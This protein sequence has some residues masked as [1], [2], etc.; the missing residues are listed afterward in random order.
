[1]T[2]RWKCENK[3]LLTLPVVGFSSISLVLFSL[4]YEYPKD[5]VTKVLH[6]CSLALQVG[7]QWSSCSIFCCGHTAWSQIIN[8]LTFPPSL[9]TSSTALATFSA[10]SNT[11]FFLLFLEGLLG[12]F[13]KIAG[14]EFGNGVLSHSLGH[15]MG[16]NTGSYATIYLFLSK[17]HQHNPLVQLS[18]I[19]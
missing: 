1:M 5:L 4:S 8:L 7:Q 13:L 12:I 16:N 18:C 3:L 2:R 10:S 17:N 6:L 11:A 9:M 15:G 14:I 19:R